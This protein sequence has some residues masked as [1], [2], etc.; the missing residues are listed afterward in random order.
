[1]AAMA[2]VAG[3]AVT[4]VAVRAQAQE[5]QEKKVKDQGE[6][7]LYNNVVKETDPAKKLQYLNQW[8]EKYPESDYYEEQLRFYGDLNQPAK[9][10]ELAPKVLAKNPKSFTALYLI[11]DSVRKLPNPNDDQLA[12]GRK[13]AQTLIDNLDALKPANVSDDAWKQNRPVIENL[14]KDRILWITMKPGT[15]AV[16]KKDY[17][18]AEQAFTKMIQQNPDNAEMTYQLGSALISQRDPNKFPQAIYEIARAVA[19]DPAKGG[20]PAQTRTQVDTYLNKIYTQYHGADDEGLKQ[21]KALALSSGPLPPAGFKIETSSEISARN[22]IEFREK[23]PQLAVWM[24]I[25][26]KLADTGGEQYFESD[27]KGADVP[28]LK[29]TL[30]DAKPACRSKELTIAL[31]DATHA[32]VTLKLDAALT[33]KPKTGAEMQFKGVPSS[34]T[35]DPFMLTMDAE[36]AGLEGVETEPCAAAPASRRAGTRR[37]AAKKE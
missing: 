21:L 15:D 1:M 14:A 30:V 37:S 7:D 22:E 27:V 29:G 24:A 12:L 18:A 23:N 9:V 35:K 26:G 25:K 33:G 36:K 6:F 20:L 28:K 16:A 10:M 31:S 8:V 3:L 13:S 17:P 2:L 34:F 19:M 11:T 32:E 4:A 5:K